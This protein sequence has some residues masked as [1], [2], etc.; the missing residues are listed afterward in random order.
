MNQKDQRKPCRWGLET[1][2]M[3]GESV[4]LGVYADKLR[5][6]IFVFDPEVDKEEDVEYE[7]GDHESIVPPES[8]HKPVT[9]SD[10]RP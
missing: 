8:R 9:Q 10:A 7:G 2:R 1:Q 6:A 5:T 4:R 3:S